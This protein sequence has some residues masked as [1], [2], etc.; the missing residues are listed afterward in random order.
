[1]A[2][3]LKD[4]TSA[5][6]SSGSKKAIPKTKNPEVTDEFQLIINSLKEIDSGLQKFLFKTYLGG[7]KA[8]WR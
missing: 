7:I 5:L 4:F 2:K 1:M 8:S 3:K 6:K